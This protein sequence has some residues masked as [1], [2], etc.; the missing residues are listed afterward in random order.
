MHFGAANIDVARELRDIRYTAMTGY[1]IPGK[2]PVA[3]YAPDE[4]IEYIYNRDFWVD[5]E[6]DILFGRI[7]RVLNSRSYDSVIS[8]INEILSCDTRSGF[9]S[10]M[11]H[12]QYFYE[13]YINYLPAFEKLVLDPCKMLFERGYKGRHISEIKK[14]T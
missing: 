2:Y 13:D 1:F 14:R 10:I 12:E 8:S 7:D 9:V 5:T 3:Y 4:L 6:T 11:I